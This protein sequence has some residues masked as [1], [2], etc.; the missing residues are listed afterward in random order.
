MRIA[1]ETVGKKIKCPG[2]ATVFAART[3]ATPSSQ[4]RDAAKPEKAAIAHYTCT[5]C[6]SSLKLPA[7]VPAGKWIKCPQCA[8]VFQPA[9][10]ETPVVAANRKRASV[11]DEGASART[12]RC[13]EVADVA[14]PPDDEE[15][16][17]RAPRRRRG[18]KNKQRKASLAFRVSA[19]VLSVFGGLLSVGLSVSCL[20]AASS[21]EVKATRELAATFAREG[22][23]DKELNAELARFDR[24]VRSSYFLLLAA[25]LGVVGGVLTVL[26]RVKLGGGLMLA[27]VPLPLIFNVGALLPLYF[28]VVGGLIA[29][30]TPSWPPRGGPPTAVV[31]LLTSGGW[32]AV[33]VVW[34]L[35]IWAL[36]KPNRE[37]KTASGTTAVVPSEQRG[38]PNP[39]PPQ[40]PPP[41]NG[42]FGLPSNVPPGT[43]VLTAEQLTNEYAANPKATN[44]KYQNKEVVVTGIVAS[45]GPKKLS[46]VS[47]YLKGNGGFQ[48]DCG[49]LAGD[50]SPSDRI[51]V[52]QQVKLLGT[53][54][55][56]EHGKTTVALRF[57]SIVQ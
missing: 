6:G 41:D 45:K 13:R 44:E 30:L 33:F 25:P 15:S 20:V 3:S 24:V 1:D 17:E 23:E 40:F 48:V 39:P 28:L 10:E 19:L 49:F 31:A 50:D 12:P 38:G 52:G 42:P 21:T 22:V 54:L 35:L 43:S 9:E 26:G 4:E 2:C 7:P 18:G 57:C 14:D 37:V 32:V 11:G 36:P 56:S 51:Q 27:A 53:F 29:F 16:E 34:V 46:A 8:T 55:V 47:V 5:S